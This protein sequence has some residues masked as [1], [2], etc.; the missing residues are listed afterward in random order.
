MGEIYACG[1]VGSSRAAVVAVRVLAGWLAGYK[2]KRP[3]G[4]FF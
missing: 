4:R 2:K 3:L 1:V